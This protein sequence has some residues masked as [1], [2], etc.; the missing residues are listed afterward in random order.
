MSILHASIRRSP[1]S[2]TEAVCLSSTHSFPRHSHDQYGV[3][4]IWRGAQRSFSGRGM[5]EAQAGDVIMVNPGEIHDGHSLH[6]TERSWLMLYFDPQ[7]LQTTAE[8]QFERACAGLNLLPPIRQDARL[9]TM[10]RQ[11]VQWLHRP[12]SAPLAIDEAETLLLGHLA[13]CQQ[14]LA[15]TRAPPANIDK[16]VQRLNAACADPLRL[17]ELAQDC[18]L[19]EYQLLRQFQ[20]RHGITPHAYLVQRRLQT[21][22][23][24]LHTPAPLADVAL[25]CGFADQSHLT[26]AFKRQFGFTPGHYRQAHLC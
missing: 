19:S 13:R 5:V 3:G 17:A 1:V 24:L 10:I 4:L 14:P 6:G 9:G 25:Q 7:Q 15:I 2:A 11:L 22:R 26:R 21:A 12:D 23:R 16:A 20:R 8:R 18:G